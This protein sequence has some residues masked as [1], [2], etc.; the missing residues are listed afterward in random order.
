LFVIESPINN[1]CVSGWVFAASTEALWRSAHHA[2]FNRST[3]AIDE[4]AIGQMMT[5]ETIKRAMED[6]TLL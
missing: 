4:K 3:G 1:I 6:T 5:N 2:S